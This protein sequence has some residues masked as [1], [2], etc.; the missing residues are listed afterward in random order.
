MSSWLFC[1]LFLF[2]IMGCRGT[3]QVDLK[4]LEGKQIIIAEFCAITFDTVGSEFDDD[5]FKVFPHC[6]SDFN[7]DTLIYEGVDL[8]CLDYNDDFRYRY[9]QA[10]DYYDEF[11]PSVLEGK[12]I[13]NFL[14]RQ[15][16]FLVTRENLLDLIAQMKRRGI[17]RDFS[18]EDGEGVRRSFNWGDMRISKEIPWSK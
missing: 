10:R 2:G 8:S 6:R 12:C 1:F 16:Y 3:D 14:D 7:F 4:R 11:E 5:V 9:E 17:N 13:K 18:I 15:T